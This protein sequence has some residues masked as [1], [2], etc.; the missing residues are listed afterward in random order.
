[1][2]I[3]DVLGQDKARFA[4]RHTLL[5]GAGYS[6][7]TVL[8]ALS[9]LAQTH[10]QT[11]VSW[12][13]R[14]PGQALSAVQNDPLEARRQLVENVLR[15]T[16]QPPPWLEFLGNCVLESLQ[17]STRITARLRCGDEDITRAA[18]EFVSLVGYA[19]DDSIYRQLQV[20]QCYATFG[21]MKLAAALLGQSAADCLTAG[22][23]LGPDT[24]NNP[25]PNFFILGAKS[26]GTN[27]NFLLQTGLRQVEDAYALLASTSRC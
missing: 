16:H 12:A 7:A 26:Y 21:P 19:P 22:A 4:N 20:H 8:T 5:I 27:S 14:R 17:A 10:P 3:P 9:Q 15:L 2:T 11:R 1:Y 13:I 24:L 18:D 6:A 23:S 25:E